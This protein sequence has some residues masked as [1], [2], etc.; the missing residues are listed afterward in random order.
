MQ[1]IH[2]DHAPAPPREAAR[3]VQDLLEALDHNDPRRAESA[4]AQLRAQVNDPRLDDIQG[5]VTDF[6]FPGA[7]TV[8]QSLYLSI[9]E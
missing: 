6:D 5:C 7:T 9:T 3:R 1:R 8:A 2:Q 4:L